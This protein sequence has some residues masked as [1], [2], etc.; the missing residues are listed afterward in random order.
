MPPSALKSLGLSSPSPRPRPISASGT[1][2]SRR[3]V[4]VQAGL[5]ACCAA[6]ALG[7]GG[8]GSA[9]AALAGGTAALAGSLAFVGVL[10]WRDRPA[11]TPW[12]ALRVLIMA[13][14]AKWAVALVSLVSLLSGRTGL[15]AVNAAPGAVVAGFCVAWAA[16]LLASMRRN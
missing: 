10:K 5:I 3:L 4:L 2:D 7:L 13:E 6:A 11:P 9:I 15:E 14:A 12:Q 8:P 1:F 16:P